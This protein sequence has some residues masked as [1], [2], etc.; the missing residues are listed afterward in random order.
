MN[1]RSQGKLKKK[2]QKNLNNVGVNTNVEKVLK[3]EELASTM[4]RNERLIKMQKQNRFVW[5]IDKGV[6]SKN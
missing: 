3:Y 1:K 6:Y 5:Y 2:W 4:K